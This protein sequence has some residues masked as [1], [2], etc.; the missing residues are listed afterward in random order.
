VVSVWSAV[1]LRAQPAAAPSALTCAE[2]E[3]F[4]KTAKIGRPRD[5]PVGVTMPRRAT[6]E[7]DNLR[8]D[9]AIQTADIQQAAY[10]TPKGTELNS[11]TRGNSTSPD[12][13]SRRC[14]S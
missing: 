8:H 4:L 5:I 2:I 10:T 13:R 14:S 11:G 3:T 12:T 6:L 7:S 1:A 9:A